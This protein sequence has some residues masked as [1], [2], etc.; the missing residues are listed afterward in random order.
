MD[1]WRFFSETGDVGYYLAVTEVLLRSVEN[2]RSLNTIR[3]FQCNPNAVII[4][5]QHDP[6]YILNIQ[7]LREM[8]FNIGRRLSGG[9]PLLFTDKQFAMQFF[10]FDERPSKDEMRR[11]IINSFLRALEEQG[12]KVFFEEPYK[13]LYNKKMLGY[14]DTMRLNHS[15]CLTF[16]INVENDDEYRKRIFSGLNYVP[17]I[18][19]FTTN[20]K[21]ELGEFSKT[22]LI[23]G[24]KSQIKKDFSINFTNSALTPYENLLLKSHV[25]KHTMSEWIYGYR[26]VRSFLSGNVKSVTI[27]TKEGYLTVIASSNRGL[28]TN[29]YITGDFYIYP[30]EALNAL[31]T[32]LQFAPADDKYIQDCIE[33]YIKLGKVKLYG[34]D[35]NDLVEGI[36]RAVI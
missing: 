17:S 25:E 12:L 13:L 27:N 2:E 24:V 9:P 35:T 7:A 22:S 5:I 21:N 30:P 19:S 1:K 14:V 23:E 20:I 33:R 28:I 34:I 16:Y 29:V 8:R 10:V 4:G 31:E 3:V 15:L 26:N 11:K 6:S 32:S 36:K 18:F